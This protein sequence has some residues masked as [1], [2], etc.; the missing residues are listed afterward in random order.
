MQ[1][2]KKQISLHIC[3]QSDQRLQGRSQTQEYMDA[4]YKIFNQGNLKNAF[5]TGISQHFMDAQVSVHPPG[6]LSGLCYSLHRV[7]NSC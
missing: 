6:Y 7:Y 1:T 2:T 3:A 5:K 4:V